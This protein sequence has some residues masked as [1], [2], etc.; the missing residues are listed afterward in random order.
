MFLAVSLSKVDFIFQTGN[1]STS[2]FR[3]LQS[4]FSLPYKITTDS[5][6]FSDE[7]EKAC[8]P[9]QGRPASMRYE[10]NVQCVHTLCT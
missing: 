8:C 4:D 10:M 7:L 2:D 1:F 9:Q 3:Y 6:Y 5:I